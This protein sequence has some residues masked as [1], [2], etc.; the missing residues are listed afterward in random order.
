VILNKKILDQYASVRHGTYTPIVC[1]APFVN[2]NFEQTGQVRACC[3]NTTHILGKWPEQK[4]MDIWRGEKAAELREY[5]RDNNLWG[6]CS[7][8]GNMI[9]AGN[10]QGVRAKYYDEYVKP[11]I[12]TALGYLNNRLTGSISYP[13]VMEFELSN[14]CN[15]ECIMCTGFFSS[16]I[17]KNREHLP[18]IVSPYN[19]AFVDELD[20]FIP[21]LTDAKFLGG[22]PFMIEIYLKIWEH[23]QKI[24]PRIRIHITTN[25][26]F[27]NDRV[28]NLLERLYAGIIVSIDSLNPETYPKIRVHGNFEKLMKNLEFFMDYAKRKNTFLSMAA[29]PITLNWRELPHML[30]FCIERNITLYFNAVFSPP[31]LSLREQPLDYQEEVIAFLKRN[32]KYEVKGNPGLPRNMSITAYND[33]IRLL[34]GWLAERKDLL[35]MKEQKVTHARE[36]LHAATQAAETEWSLQAITDVM[37]DLIEI[38]KKGYFEQEHAKQHRLA[39]L[40]V[41]SRDAD[42]DA[43]IRQFMT[44]YEKFYNLPPAPGIDEKTRVIAEMIKNSPRRNEVLTSMATTQPLMI[45]QVF[46]NKS[47]DEL[48]VELNKFLSR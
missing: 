1:H 11:G 15:L 48:K 41:A 14:Q 2:L 47:V 6:G 12:A 38:D 28:K 25:G 46:V 42:L 23:I 5:I 35:E 13:R 9:V 32:K 10:H 31:E 27:L 7:E 16:M 24:N 39:S 37:L 21:H 34:E 8:C 43:S 30:D 44:A 26:N 4:I 19:D 33:F 18:P 22:E 40:L 3:Y 20:E 45:A 29:C 17:R 36:A